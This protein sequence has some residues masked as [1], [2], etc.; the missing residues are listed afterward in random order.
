MT[1]QQR[2]RLAVALFVGVPVVGLVLLAVALA[3]KSPVGVLLALALPPVFAVLVIG[4]SV[5]ARRRSG[6]LVPPELQGLDPQ[7]RRIVTA[8][9]TGGG[10]VA[11]PDLATAVVAH[12]RRQ[13]LAMGLLLAGGSIG[14]ILR[15]AALASDRRDGWVIPDLL[16]IAGWLVLA[17]MMVSS[18]V[19]ARRAI[20]ANRPD[21]G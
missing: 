11:D 8:A 18:V 4:A 21:V 14:V 7:D 9:V 10:R 20:A 19:R 12:A 15:I 2:W 13:Q 17:V 5:R 16:V 1:E 3:T 6:V